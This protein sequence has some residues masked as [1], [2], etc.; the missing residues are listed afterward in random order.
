MSTNQKRILVE[1]ARGLFR[2]LGRM[3]GHD[4]LSG[5][6]TEHNIWEKPEPELLLLVGIFRRTRAEILTLAANGDRNARAII[7]VVPEIPEKMKFQGLK[8]VAERVS[9]LT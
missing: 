2:L 4:K 1:T 3:N 6:K 7:K 5:L 8:E 9:T